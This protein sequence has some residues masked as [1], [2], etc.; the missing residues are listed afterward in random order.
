MAME[1]LFGVLEEEE[2]VT[3]LAGVAPVLAEGLDDR[4]G[5]S[6]GFGASLG[7]VRREFEGPAEGFFEAPTHKGLAA[8]IKT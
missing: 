4:E 1:E 3:H 8:A 2:G 7:A 5:K 6:E